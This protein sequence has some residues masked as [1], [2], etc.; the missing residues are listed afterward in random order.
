M[1]CWGKASSI[2]MSTPVKSGLQ[3]T[4]SSYL[5]SVLAARTACLSSKNLMHVNSRG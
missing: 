5:P 3:V 4:A 2:P 1:K